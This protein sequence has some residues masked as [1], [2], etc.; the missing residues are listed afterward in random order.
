MDHLIFTVYD[1]KTAA[2]LPPFYMQTIPAA[3]RAITDTCNDPTHQFAMHPEDYILFHL[4]RFD[5]LTAKFDL[6]S[7]PISLCTCLELMAQPPALGV[8]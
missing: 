5:D 8:S 2:Y 6:E 3:I 4:G 1:S 7:A